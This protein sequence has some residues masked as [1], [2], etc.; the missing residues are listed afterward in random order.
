MQ[1][2]PA[3]VMVL[4]GAMM[5]TQEPT[6]EK[7]ESWSW[8]VEDATPKELGLEAGDWLQL[9]APY[10]TRQGITRLCV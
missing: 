3:L 4:P 1:A 6:L 10:C 5:S 9:S 2:A 8:L 7:E